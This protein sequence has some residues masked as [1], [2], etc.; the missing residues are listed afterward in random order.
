MTRTP[1]L[2]QH[3]RDAAHPGA[4]DA[5]EMHRLREPPCRFVAHAP[6]RLLMIRSTS[7]T[8]RSRRVR[9][10][11]GGAGRG[12]LLEARA[13]AEQPGDESRAAGRRSSRRRPRA[14]PRRR[15]PSSARSCAGGR[16]SRTGTGTR[17]AGLPSAASS[18]TEP[19]ERA[20]TRSAAAMACRQAVSVGHQ[21]VA[22]KPLAARLEVGA[23]ARRGSAARRRGR[24][25]SPGHAPPKASTQAR[26]MLCAPWLPPKASTT[27]RSARSS[28]TSRPSSAEAWRCAGPAAAR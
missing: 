6:P 14:A 26:L 13:V 4:A 9:P 17:M 2:R 22:L 11:E 7:S 10:P 27:G 8:T 1:E 3:H 16:P 28:N 25:G 24:A 19:P 20:T 18:A 15:R 5:D 23:H 12:H 21:A